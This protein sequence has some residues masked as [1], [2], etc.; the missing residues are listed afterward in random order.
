MMHEW[1]YAY[2]FSIGPVGVLVITA[3]LVWPV[4]RICQ[5]A[6]Y[7]GPMALLVLIPVVNLIFLY[8]FAF[9]DWPSLKKEERAA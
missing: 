9:S 7:P 2:G 4:W 3:L 1:G 5:K 8:W 6:G